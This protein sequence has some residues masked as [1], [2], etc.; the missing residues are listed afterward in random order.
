MNGRRRPSGV[1]KSSLQGPITSGRVSAN[2]AL[3]G[4]HQRDQRGRVRELPEQRRQVRRGRRQRTTPGPSAPTPSRSVVRAADGLC[5]RRRRLRRDR[6]RR[7]RRPCAR[8]APPPPPRRAAGP[9]P[10]RSGSPP[11]RRRRSSSRGGRRRPSGTP[12]PPGR[13]R[14]HARSTRNASRTS[15]ICPCRCGLRATSRTITVTS[16]GSL[17]H[18]R[19]RILA[20]ARSFSSAGSSAVSTRRNRSSSSP[21][22]SRKTVASTSSL[23]GK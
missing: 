20:S 15:S 17:R 8:H 23:D 14:S 19:S 21:Q 3:R 5:R 1:W 13:A 6:R 16:E 2:E 11:G 12:L 22:F 9:G 10:S 18:V 7:R 4:E